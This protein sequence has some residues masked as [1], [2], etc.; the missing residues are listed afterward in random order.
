MKLSLLAAALV[1]TACGSEP[2]PV[3]DDPAPTA[4]PTTGTYPAFAPADYAY[5]LSVSCFCVDAGAPVRITVVD[6]EVTDAVYTKDGR[7]VDEG[8]QAPDYRRLTIEEIIA[9]AN[10]TEAASV[11]V[12]WPQGQDYPSSVYVDQDEQMMDEEIGYAVSDVVVG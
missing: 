7:G 8:T 3:A 5:T 2:T 9:A 4:E 11:E 10:D 12:E 1:L 6:G